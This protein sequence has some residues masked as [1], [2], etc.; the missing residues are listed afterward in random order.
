MKLTLHHIN[1]VTR[2]VPEMDAFYRDVMQLEQPQSDLPNLEKTKGYAGD[3]SIR[4]DGAIQMHLAE[5]D[6]AAG[7]NTG[8]IVNPVARGHIAFRTDDL[9]AFLAILDAVRAN[10]LVHRAGHE[11]QAT[12]GR[13]G[14]ADVRRPPPE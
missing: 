4:G 1:L 14:S 12:A 11:Y 10:L 6:H 2:D 3:V 9:P 13:D 7:F 5:R 8:Q